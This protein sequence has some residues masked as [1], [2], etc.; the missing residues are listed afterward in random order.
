MA[1]SRVG[2]RGLMQLMPATAKNMARQLRLPYARAKLVD[3]NFNVRLG[4]AYLKQLLQTYRGDYVLAVA[5]YNAGPGRVNAWLDEL[6]DPRDGKQD[7]VAWIEQIPFTETRIYVQRV[8]EGLKVYRRVLTSR[9]ERI[10][11]E[12]LPF[13][14]L[15]PIIGQ[16]TGGTLVGASLEEGQSAPSAVNVAPALTQPTP[17]LSG[18]P[19]SGKP[20][21]GKTKNK[22]ESNPG[23]EAT[24]P[25]PPPIF[26][27]S[28]RPSDSS[29]LNLPADNSGLCDRNCMDAQTIANLNDENFTLR[30]V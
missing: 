26:P 12:G 23:D 20:D 6:G 19:S 9:T 2:A 10:K 17:P 27:E 22:I 24:T 3:V 14:V 28:S 13:S 8:F 29:R 15:P 21:A 4:G 1:Q 5:A 11:R 18:N 25:I 30:M 16:N 7:V